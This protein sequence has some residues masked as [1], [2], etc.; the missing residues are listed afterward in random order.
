MRLASPPHL[1]RGGEDG[2]GAPHGQHVRGKGGNIYVFNVSLA[3]M[4]TAGG[5]HRAL[6]KACVTATALRVP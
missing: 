5:Q 1:P 6:N 4:R 3:A 2:G